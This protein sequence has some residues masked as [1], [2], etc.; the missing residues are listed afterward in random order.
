MTNQIRVKPEGDFCVPKAIQLCFMLQVLAPWPH[1]DSKICNGK[2]RFCS[3]K[4][5]SQKILQCKKSQ[6]DGRIN[7]K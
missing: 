4:F 6:T 3:R 1:D 2:I 7:E 5:C